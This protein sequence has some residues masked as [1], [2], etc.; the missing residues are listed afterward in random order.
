MSQNW[1]Y[2]NKSQNG[3]SAIERLRT[4]V[5]SMCAGLRADFG[6][7]NYQPKLTGIDCREIK[8]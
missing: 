3:S 1:L 4:G 8:V 7:L 6:K 2:A 5:S